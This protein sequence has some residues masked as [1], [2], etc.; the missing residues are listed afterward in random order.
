MDLSASTWWWVICG[1]LVAAELASGTFYLLMLALGA[2]AGA[3]AAHAGLGHS[4]QLVAGAIVGGGAT[5]GWYLHRR[6]AALR[7][8]L[9]PN[10]DLNLDIGE[11]V[12]V[13]SWAADGSAKVRYRGAT[14][15]ARFVGAGE[16]QAGPHQISGIDGSRLLLKRQKH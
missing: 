11:P 13:E 16:P 6:K 1:V 14:W 5:L 3:V 15:S 10:R 12:A 8:S 9:Q 7:E 4:S 2:A